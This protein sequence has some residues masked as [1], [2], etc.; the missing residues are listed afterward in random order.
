MKVR[1]PTSSGENDGAGQRVFG[2]REEFAQINHKQ[3]GVGG[4][5]G[6]LAEPEHPGGL[7]AHEASEGDA[8]VEIRTAGLLKARGNFGEAADDDAHSGAGRQHGVGTVVADEG[9]H[10]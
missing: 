8:G 4:G 7:N 3:V 5:R 10:G 9:G 6:H 1:R 2:V